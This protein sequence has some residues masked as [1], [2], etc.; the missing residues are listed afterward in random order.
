M[1]KLETEMVKSSTNS[2]EFK[3]FGCIK[4]RILINKKSMHIQLFLLLKHLIEQK[5]NMV[6]TN[7]PYN[8]LDKIYKSI[9]ENLVVNQNI[10][11]LNLRN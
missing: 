11:Q 6:S 10:V 3:S 2:K 8:N 9:K 7:H 5:I 1:A 4:I